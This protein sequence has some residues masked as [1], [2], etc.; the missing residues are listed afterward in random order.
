METKQVGKRHASLLTPIPP[1]MRA[2][3]PVDGSDTRYSQLY[4]PISKDAYKMAGVKGFT[5]SLPFNDLLHDSIL[6][7]S[8]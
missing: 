2:F 7:N 1:E 4:R 3:Q 8:L 6:I 5:P